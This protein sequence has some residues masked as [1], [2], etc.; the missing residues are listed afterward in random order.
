[1]SAARRASTWIWIGATV[2]FT[3]VGYAF[4]KS[5]DKANVKHFQETSTMLPHEKDWVS[6]SVAEKS[7]TQLY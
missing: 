7:S 5:R 1:M 2:A 4:V 6:K 3:A